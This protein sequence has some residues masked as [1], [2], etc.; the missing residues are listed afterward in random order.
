MKA[1]FS[2]RTCRTCTVHLPFWD[3]TSSWIETDR[4]E[5]PRWLLTAHVTFVGSPVKGEAAVP[6]FASGEQVDF[7][8]W[9]ESKNMVNSCYRIPLNISR[10]VGEKNHVLKHFRGILT[11][12][13]Q[14][15]WLYFRLNL[16]ENFRT[17]IL[18]TQKSN[19]KE[20]K[21]PLKSKRKFVWKT[22]RYDA[23]RMSL[24]NMSCQQ[25]I[26]SKLGWSE[27]ESQ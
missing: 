19:I 7:L 6:L 5:I 13:L 2:K 18:M 16:E 22:G 27:K 4:G 17:R 3:F 15:L 1:S 24:C 25:Q 8:W 9:H 21:S 23:F 11:E 10:W 12:T 20:W 14:L 26:V